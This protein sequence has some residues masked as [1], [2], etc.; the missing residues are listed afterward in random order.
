MGS[1][2]RSRKNLE[3]IKFRPPKKTGGFFLVDRPPDWN[4]LPLD[5]LVFSRVHR[6]PRGKKKCRGI[7]KSGRSCPQSEN[8][9]IRRDP[10]QDGQ[11]G[12]GTPELFSQNG[13]A[14]SFLPYAG[15]TFSH[16]LDNL[17]ITGHLIVMKQVNIAEF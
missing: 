10:P 8:H 7:S 12:K 2:G 3:R 9:G 15:K 14:A 6:R 11:D 5:R 4:L 1:S 13:F 17:T 16:P